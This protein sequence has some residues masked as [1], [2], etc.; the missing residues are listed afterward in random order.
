M[1]L[2]KKMAMN[3]IRANNYPLAIDYLNKILVKDPRH[4]EALFF[5]KKVLMKIKEIKQGAV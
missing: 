5:K 4:K 3:A 1:E 2:L